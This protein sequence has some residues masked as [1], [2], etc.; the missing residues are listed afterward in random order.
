VPTERIATSCTPITKLAPITAATICATRRV[1]LG[2]MARN[3][4]TVSM[5]EIA[6]ATIAIAM[7]TP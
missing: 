1:R 2:P 7:T 5:T 6:T 4:A 3:S